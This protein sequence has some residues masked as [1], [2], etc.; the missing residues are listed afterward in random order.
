MPEAVKYQSD[1]FASEIRIPAKWS[2]LQREDEGSVFQKQ[3]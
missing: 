3:E 1:M 2:L